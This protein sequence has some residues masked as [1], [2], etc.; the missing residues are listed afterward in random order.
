MG[1][2]KGLISDAILPVQVDASD[3]YDALCLDEIIAMSD[4]SA[5]IIY[6]P[7]SGIPKE[8]KGKFT[9]GIINSPED[10]ARALS[11]VRDI[12]CIDDISFICT[13]VDK[14]EQITSYYLQQVYN[15][16]LVV[17]GEFRVIATPNGEP[18]AVVGLFISGINID[19]TPS[20]TAK[21]AEKS[22]VLERSTR[23][24]QVALVVY[25]DY[26]D[27]IFL[28]WMLTINSRDP[29]KEREVIINAK[30]CELITSIPH[31]IS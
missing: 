13:K 30:T 18:V 23:V 10:A 29:L 4:G 28:C 11:S 21:E 5:D 19:I 14:E 3:Y 25:K 12:M 8:I 2:N 26:S 17:N 16:I 24:S 1:N 6:F 7:D 20:F 22:V 9:T 15:G 31:S 27:E